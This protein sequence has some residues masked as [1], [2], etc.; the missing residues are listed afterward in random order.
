MQLS[1]ETQTG[2]FNVLEACLTLPASG[3]WRAEL[4]I[5]SDDLADTQGQGTLTLQGEGEPRTFRGAFLQ[6]SVFASRTRARLVPAVGLF[7]PL[8]AKFY[9]KAAVSAIAKDILQSVQEAL[10]P[11]SDHLSVILPSWSRREVEAASLAIHELCSQLQ[12]SWFATESGLVHLGTRAASE[13]TGEVIVLNENTFR[14]TQELDLPGLDLVPGQT[15]EGR[16]VDR[17][18]LELSAAKTRIQV[19][20]GA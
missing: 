3:L 7:L 1:L 12:T 8:P 15:I 20:L 2:M 6:A 4:L 9:R 10:D 17:L 13:Y 19:R 5:E 16:S 18:T 14:Q 11:A